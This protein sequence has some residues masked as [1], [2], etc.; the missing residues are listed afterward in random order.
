MKN[1][2]NRAIAAKKRTYI[3][4]ATQKIELAKDLMQT[5]LAIVTSGQAGGH[6][7]TDPTQVF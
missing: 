3:V 5:S 2:I 1:A 7:V 6:Y 4:P